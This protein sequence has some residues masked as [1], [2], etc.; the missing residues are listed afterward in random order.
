MDR[1]NGYKA[2]LKEAGLPFDE[3]IVRSY[4]I[5]RRERLTL[6]LPLHYCLHLSDPITAAFCL[7]EDA[8]LAA[9]EAAAKM[10]LRVPGDLEIAGF[11]DEHVHEA[12]PM[13]FTRVIQQKSE[14]GRAAVRLL[15]ERI[16]GNAPKDTRHVVL[17]AEVIPSGLAKLS[18]IS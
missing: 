9:L 6:E 12:L 18:M 17:P 3:E 13:P 15:L 5:T 4:E 8:V 1:E 14:M 7:N 16:F 11:F 2:A 10:G